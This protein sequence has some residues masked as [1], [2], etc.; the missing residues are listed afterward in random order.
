MSSAQQLGQFIR[1]DAAWWTFF[2]R[3][4]HIATGIMWMGMLLHVNFLQAPILP[5][6]EPAEYHAAF[7]NDIARRGAVLVSL[8]RAGDARLRLE[9]RLSGGYLARALTLHKGGGQ[10]SLIDIT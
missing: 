4:L 2:V 9:P 8:R 1:L 6:I 10:N 3:S 7:V 5:K